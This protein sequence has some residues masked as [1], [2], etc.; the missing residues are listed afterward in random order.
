MLNC[1]PEFWT[2]NLLSETEINEVCNWLMIWQKACVS[3]DS[4]ASDFVE[5]ASDL[6]SHKLDPAFKTAMKHVESLIRHIH[7]LKNQKENK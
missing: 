4:I 2:P 7:A 5:H 6:P 3:G 1:T